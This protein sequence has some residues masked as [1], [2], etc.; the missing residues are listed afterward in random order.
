MSL[1]VDSD[2]FEEEDEGP[3]V[4]QFAELSGVEYH[5]KYLFIFLILNQLM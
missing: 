2:S 1:K 3:S 5:G 4:K